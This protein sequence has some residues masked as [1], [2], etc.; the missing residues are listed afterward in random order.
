MREAGFVPPSMAVTRIARRP[1]KTMATPSA[2]HSCVM[3]SRLS[4]DI[5]PKPLT[6]DLVTTRWAVPHRT[7]SVEPKYIRT[8]RLDAAS[9]SHDYH[10]AIRQD[11]S[12]F[13]AILRDHVL[14]SAAIFLTRDLHGSSIAEAGTRTP[15]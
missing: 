2:I 15:V 12:C 13:G 4:L 10:Y 11:G 3:I 5:S 6:T 7:A 8:P 9:S 1:T 14:S